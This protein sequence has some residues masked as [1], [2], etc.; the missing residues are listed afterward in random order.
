MT[1]E[2]KGAPF[3][4]VIQ[5]EVVTPCTLFTKHSPNGILTLNLFCWLLPLSSESPTRTT[6]FRES[7]SS[8]QY[9][10]LAP[11][12]TS[13]SFTTACQQKTD[14]KRRVSRLEES[15]SSVTHQVVPNLD[16][17]SDARDATGHSIAALNVSECIG[18]VV[19]EKNV[20][21]SY[22]LGS[23]VWT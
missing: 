14:Q 8:T 5:I 1:V 3:S 7:A 15:T 22:S 16:H 11:T 17:P 12:N 9:W 2:W 6:H 21:I 13:P 20:L 19:I 18:R 10:P 23:N 4:C